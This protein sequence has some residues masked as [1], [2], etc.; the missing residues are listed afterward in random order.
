MCSDRD[1]GNK[2]RLEMQRGYLRNDLGDQL[3]IKYRL[4]LLA[5]YFRKYWPYLLFLLAVSE[6]LVVVTGF[7][8]YVSFGY[9]KYQESVG[10]EK[11]LWSIMPTFAFLNGLFLAAYTANKARKEI[12]L[13]RK[14]RTKRG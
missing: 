9:D 6:I 5:G 8:S 3:S 11:F 14:R 12:S 10:A 4:E 2:V 7:S 13:K 1:T